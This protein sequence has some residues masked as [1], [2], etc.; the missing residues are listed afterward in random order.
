MIFLTRRPSLLPGAGDIKA[1]GLGRCL[2]DC[3]LIWGKDAQFIA[4]VLSI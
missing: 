2:A 3:S 1:M 4:F